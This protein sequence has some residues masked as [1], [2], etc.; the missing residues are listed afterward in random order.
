MALDAFEKEYGKLVGKKVVGT[1]KTPPEDGQEEQYGLLFD[2]GTVAWVLQDPE[3]NG[4]GFL[5]IEAPSKETKDFLKA[6][7]D[8]KFRDAMKR[9]FGS[10]S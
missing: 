1:C 6:K 2:D 4:P 9:T 7:A 10:Q 8:A 3:G 5:E